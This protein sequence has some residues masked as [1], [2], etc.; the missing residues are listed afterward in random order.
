MR[1][2]FRLRKDQVSRHI[3]NIAVIL[4]SNSDY[5]SQC[6]PGAAVTTLVTS[7]KATTTATRTS[8][9]ATPSAPAA[10]GTPAGSG[11]GTT[12]QSGYY[13]IRGTWLEHVFISSH[14]WS[15]LLTSHQLWPHP[16][17]TSTCKRSLCTPLV[18]LCSETTLP[19]ANSR[20]LMVSS[21]SSSQR[22][23]QPSSFCTLSCQRR[24][25]S[26]TT[27]FQ[28]HSLRLRTLTVN[29]PGRVTA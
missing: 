27:H 22:L 6:Q 4:T 10:T 18:L 23:A 5:Y 19:P 3:F 1:R 20:S 2:K 26:T 25:I 24:G 7:T 15:R 11:P 8:A 12:L 28:L 13:W 29:L 9:A 17:S 21:F 14:I 16:T